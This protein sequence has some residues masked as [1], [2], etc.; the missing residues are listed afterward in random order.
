MCWVYVS[1]LLLIPKRLSSTVKVVVLKNWE[2]GGGGERQ[3]IHEAFPIE[4]Y[5]IPHFT[6]LNIQY[7]FFR[8]SF[9]IVTSTIIKPQFATLKF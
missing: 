3:H 2:E 1:N 5:S 6:A 4:N 8:P 9:Q 7:I